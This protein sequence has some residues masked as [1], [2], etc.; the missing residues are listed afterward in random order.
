LSARQNFAL[1]R[2]QNVFDRQFSTDGL[3]FIS[4]EH[5]AELESAWLESDDVLLNITGDGITFARACMVPDEILPACVNQHVSIIRADPEICL[6]GYLLSYLTHPLIKRYIESFNVGGSRR[7]ITKGHI[8]SFIVPL[9]PLKEQQAITKVLGNLDAKIELNRKIN[10]TLE[11]IARAIFKSWFVDFD[12]AWTKLAL[13]EAEEAEGEQPYGMDAETAALFPDAFVDSELGPIPEGWQTQRL[14]DV[15]SVNRHSIAGDYPHSQIEYIDIS[16]VTE[17]KLA[18]TT[19]Y[20][21]SESPSRARR[22]VKQGDTIWS[23]VRPNRKSYLFIHSPAENLVVSTG[24][25]VLSPSL[26]P[27]SYLYAWV[28]TEQFVSYLVSNTTGSAYP[29]VRAQRFEEAQMLVPPTELLKKYDEIAAPMRDL[30][31]H[32]DCESE[33]LVELRDTLLPKLISG[34]LRIPGD[35]E[36]V[37]ESRE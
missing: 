13:S 12:P 14:G 20:D 8:E 7:A 11:A 27:A 30:I 36:S 16:S 21:I 3:A 24:F 28:T 17:G 1:V 4:D 33:T 22:L 32:N 31:A 23:T 29:A 26:I 35:Q 6:P 15:A 25:A 10:H 37:G 19:T 9:P 2:S 5:A 34:Q 18:G